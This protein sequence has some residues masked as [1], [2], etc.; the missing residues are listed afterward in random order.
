MVLARP[1]MNIQEDRRQM[2]EKFVKP[3]CVLL[4]R[5]SPWRAFAK[6]VP[7]TSNQMMINV[8]ALMLS[9]HQETVCYKTASARLA[10]TTKK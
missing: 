8:S 4:T 9:V 2:M 5:F 1:V 6:T 3:R 7:Q 10:K